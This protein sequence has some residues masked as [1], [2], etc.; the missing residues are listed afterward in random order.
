MPEPIRLTISVF[1]ESRE[2]SL[3][4]LFVERIRKTAGDEVEVRSVQNRAELLEALPETDYLIGL[5]PADDQFSRLGGRLKWIQL[6]GSLGDLESA[7]L[8]AMRSGVRV[9]TI[10]SIRAAQIAEHA[11]AL[12][13]ALTRRLEVCLA[14]Q[15]DQRWAPHVVARQLRTL[16]G[17]TVGVIAPSIVAREIALR[18][19]PFGAHILATRRNHSDE[20]LEGVDEVMPESQLAEM[21]ARSDVVIVAAPKTPATEALIGRVQFGHMPRN[22]IVIDVG[23]GGV[24]QTSS[25]LEALQRQRIA[26]AGID[27]F[28]SEP[29]APNSLFWSMPNVIITP[30]VASASPSYW[31]EATELICKNI[32]RIRRDEPL[33]DEVDEQWYAPTG[34]P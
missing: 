3:P 27:V 6:T 17:A 7:L 14:L 2:W 22:A 28:D 33:I 25:L 20:P 34:R 1:N 9:T 12:T 5:P 21:L 32:A 18:A 10:A 29:L 26:G 15:A 24:I 19:R 4:S 31:F 30:H 23:R 16:R 8:P 13:L 11:L